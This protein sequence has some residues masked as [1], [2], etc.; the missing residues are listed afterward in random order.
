MIQSEKN[1]LIGDKRRL[2]TVKRKSQICKSFKFKVL[3]SSLTSL[4]KEQLKMYFVEA[5]W[6]YNYLLSHQDGLYEI[7]TK[8]KELSNITRLDKDKNEVNVTISHITSSIKQE[9]IQ[10]ICNEIKGLSVLKKKG[11]NAG[12]L[13]YKSEINSINLKQYGNTHSIRGSRFKIQGIKQPIRVSGLKQ[14]SKYDNINFANAK[15]LYDGYDYYIT[16]TCYI[17]KE[18]EKNIEYKN[19]IIGLDFGVKTTITASNGDKANVLVR[20][21]DTLK[22][23]QRKLARQ[24]KRSNSWYKTKSL[25]RKQYTHLN[26]KKNDFANKIVH[27][28]LIENKIIVMQDEQISSWKTDMMAEKI[29]HSVLGRIKSKL[30]QSNRVVILDKLYPTTKYCFNCGSKYDITLDE[31]T[32]ICPTCGYKE[33]RDIHAAKNM[34]YLYQQYKDAVGTTDTSKPVKLKFDKNLLRS[35]KQQ[36]L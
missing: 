27:K 18:P 16:L 1:K 14:I 13:K 22:K 21:S 12:K 6:I 19:D 30:V 5:K 24:Q 34:I 23:L 9:L 8:Y 35:W 26:N 10:S 20:E 7:K 3:R 4:Q 15:L 2:T 32:Y 31:R 28:L 17:D 11:Y 29:Q 33:D 36:I 25:I